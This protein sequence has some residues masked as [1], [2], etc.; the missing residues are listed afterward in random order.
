MVQSPLDD[1]GIRLKVVFYKT[2]K[3][4]EPVREWLKSLPVVDKRIIGEDIKTV[5]FGFPIGMP[6]V[7]KLEAGIWEVRSSLP[8]R[9]ARVLFTVVDGFM[10]LLHGFIKKSQKTPSED[11]HLARE[12]LSRLRGKK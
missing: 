10:I 11:L 4:S 3:G 12:R 7:R 2:G 6:L 8:N 9:I 1:E 5:Q